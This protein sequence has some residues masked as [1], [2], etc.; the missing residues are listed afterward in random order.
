MT[1]R[2]TIISNVE[3]C[4]ILKKDYREDGPILFF[5]LASRLNVGLHL[6][7]RIRDVDI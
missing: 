3:N 2:V 4:T 5:Y 6:F 7:E 1:S